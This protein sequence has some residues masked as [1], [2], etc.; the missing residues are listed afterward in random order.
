MTE[1][2]VEI[3]VW[4]DVRDSIKKVKGTSTYSEFLNRLVQQLT[5]N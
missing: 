4:R 5:N 1:R 2:M 3:P